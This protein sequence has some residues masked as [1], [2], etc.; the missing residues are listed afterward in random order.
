MAPTGGGP[1][2]GPG[3]GSGR[4]FGRRFGASP[5]RPTPAGP[6]RS[7]DRPPRPLVEVR[8]VVVGPG[9]LPAQPGLEPVLQQSGHAEAPE[10]DTGAEAPERDTGAE[11]PE[12]DPGA[13]APGVTRPNAVSISTS[14]EASALARPC[15]P[16]SAVPPFGQS[17]PPD[18][19]PMAPPALAIVVVLPDGRIPAGRIPAPRGPAPSGTAR[20]AFG[21][22]WRRNADRR[23]R[24]DR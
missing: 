8:A 5:G 3:G 2:G 21:G 9:G 16:P 12:R 15:R 19:C 13:E 14:G 17:E 22:S 10:R 23:A 11:A 24:T 6:S 1:G 20:K 18:R 4:R 7:S